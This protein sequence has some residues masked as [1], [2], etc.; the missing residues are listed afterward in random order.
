M[1]LVITGERR[2]G[3]DAEPA[4]RLPAAGG[5]GTG[6]FAAGAVALAGVLLTLA[7]SLAM[8]EQVGIQNVQEAAARAAHGTEEVQ[9]RLSLASDTTRA[10]AAFFASSAQVDER[11]F[12]RFVTHVMPAGLGIEAALWCERA[13]PETGCV[14]RHAEPGRLRLEAGRMLEEDPAAAALLAAALHAGEP[15]GA[16]LEG[17]R[18]GGGD[19]PLLA[20]AVPVSE[21]RVSAGSGAGPERGR[22]GIVIGLVP[23]RRIFAPPSEPGRQGADGL[24]VFD[25]MMPSVPIHVGGMSAIKDPA[26]SIVTVREVGIGATRWLLHWH[27]APSALPSAFTL[28]PVAVL[29]GGLAI[30]FAVTAYLVLARRRSSE[31]ADLAASLAAANAELRERERKYREIYENSVEGVFQTLPDGRFLSAN[32][33]LA[34]LYGYA[35]SSELIEDMSDVGRQLYVDP[36]RRVEFVRQMEREGE[37]HNFESR[38][39][40]RDGTVIWITESARAVRDAAGRLLYYEGK[41]EDVTRRKEAEEVLRLAK[42]QSDLANRAKSEFLA[43][44]SHELR[45]PLNAIIGF[46]EIIKDE[47]F[48]PA[49]RQEYVEYARDIH[50]SGRLLLALINDILDMSKIEAGKKE[51]NDSV[52]DVGRVAESCVRLIR[53]RA[54]AHAV[55]LSIEMPPDLPFLRAEERALKQIVNNLLSNAVK[56]TPEGGKVVLSALVEPEGGL[57]LR[58]SDTGIGMAREDLPKA[59]APFG[60]IESSLSG[61]TQG[62]GLG[63]PLVVALTELHGGCLEIESAPGRGTVAKVCLPA[64]RVIRKVA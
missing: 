57:I 43:N 9:H 18:Y 59:L 5:W 33:A 35:G 10:I 60:Q 41:V 27:G 49:G 48:G 55:H 22:A 26:S 30:T 50:D 64:E 37:V 25:S 46:S 52:I 8:H 63:L 61:K 45:T 4:K 12:S 20:V 56:F 32:P 44:M 16:L 14:L 62:T 3:P 23:A 6:R 58:V 21:R 7:L 1:E 28:S 38:I 15:T 51:L 31:V 2:P 17:R 34:R 36:G 40:R 39:R 29:F 19:D 54:D 53:P 13:S 11:E 42:E 24:V 47:L